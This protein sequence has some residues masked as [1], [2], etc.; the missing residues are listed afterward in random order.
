[1]LSN[2]LVSL[3][4]VSLAYVASANA[5]GY[6]TGVLVGGVDWYPGYVPGSSTES[7]IRKIPDFGKIFSRFS[8]IPSPI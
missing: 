4:T 5:H 3:L 2:S 6:V 8:R 7:I 1:M